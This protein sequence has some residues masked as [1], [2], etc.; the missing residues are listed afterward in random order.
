MIRDIVNLTTREK[1]KCVYNFHFNEILKYKNAR[2]RFL[3]LDENRL[4]T[5]NFIIEFI[6]PVKSY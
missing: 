5:R 3:I 6:D 1:P 4:F 2:L